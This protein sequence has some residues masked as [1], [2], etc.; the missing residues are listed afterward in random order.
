KNTIVPNYI[1]NSGFTEDIRGRTK[2]GSPQSTNEFYVYNRQTDTLLQI[3]PD[4]I[5]GIHDLPE[6]LKDYPSRLEEQAKHPPL[7]AV[8]I[9]GLHWSPKGTNCVLDI[10]ADDNKD[11]WLMLLNASTGK[12]KLLDRQHDSAWIGGPGIGWGSSIN[13]G[14]ITENDFW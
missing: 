11:R 12:L 2:V 8:T 14:W 6:Y 1:T 5:P 3:K 10:F 7:R 9:Q 13:T 4:S